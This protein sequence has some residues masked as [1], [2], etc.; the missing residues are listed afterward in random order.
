MKNISHPLLKNLKKRK[1]KTV[2]LQSCLQSLKA[3]IN[4]SKI[5]DSCA[6]FLPRCLFNTSILVMIA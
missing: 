5:F 6:K 2:F 3:I 1:A 4:L